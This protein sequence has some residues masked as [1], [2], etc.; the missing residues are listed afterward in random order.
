M[1]L[2]T[3]S[4]NKDSFKTLTFKAGLN[5]IL[6]DRTEKSS[7]TDSRN[8]V[9]KTTLLQ[10]IDYC[11]GGRIVE[12]DSLHK[13]AG[14]EWSFTLV[15]EIGGSQL[16]VTRNIDSSDV[17]IAGD[18]IYKLGLTEKAEANEAVLGP[19]E[20]SNFLGFKSFQLP[21]QADRLPNAP[22]FRG[23]LRHF[24]RFRNEAYA[25]PFKTFGSQ[26][27]VQIQS[28]NAFLLG[29]NWQY[30]LEWQRLKD[31][32]KRLRALSS[33]DVEELGETLAELQ[34]RR[35]RETAQLHRLETDIKEFRVL[36]E[37]REIE[38]RANTA[39]REMVVI[40]NQVLV[41]AREIELYQEQARAE[42]TD[43]DEVKVE[44][45]FKQVGIAFPDGLR[46]TLEQ[47]RDF[48]ASVISN[49]RQYLESEVRRLNALQDSRERRMQ[50]LERDRRDDLLLLESHGALEDYASMQKRLGA[51]SA[52]I[53]EL[54]GSIEAIQEVRRGKA[55]LRAETLELAERVE[56]DLEERGP[57]YEGI[58]NRFSEAFEA[59]YGDEAYLLVDVG[60]AGYRFRVK[61]PREGSTGTGKVGIFA[62]DLAIS[63]AWRSDRQGCG[64]LAHDSVLFDGVDERQTA[65]AIALAAESAATYDYQYLLTANSDDLTTDE[66]QRVGLDTDDHVVL[67]LTD[68]DE[69][70]GLLGLRI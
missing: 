3:V 58:L 48:H 13:L 34:A 33:S 61:V 49:R 41:T 59:L 11:L 1:K 16:S 2:V 32:E 66:F 50:Q 6:A 5:I 22:T 63:E 67:R 17:S 21:N 39:A 47:T 53:S 55:A 51:I 12:G 4:S 65:T 45:L 29:L 69:S 56:Q 27:P 14:K 7:S 68:A 24:L 30:A 15:I 36:P 23:L 60:D 20:W 25:S 70:G 43:E 28:E 62:Y 8:G 10:I 44:G 42:F 37:Y 40:A 19:V 46:R 54:S 18:D 31:R 26:P 52:S 64:F 38:R 57:S 9:G 35:A